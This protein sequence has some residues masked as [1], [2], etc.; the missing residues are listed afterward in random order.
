MKLVHIIFLIIFFILIG[1]FSTTGIKS[2]IV[3]LGDI[4]L[5][6]PFLIWISTQI[7]PLW[8]KI[9][10]ILIGSTTISYNARNYIFEFK[11]KL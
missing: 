11:N 4:F 10:L 1:W 7:E 2:Q 6:G 9:I 5:Y 8:A 3:R